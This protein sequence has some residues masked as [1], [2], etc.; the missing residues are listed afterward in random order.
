[1]RGDS[2]KSR[3][4]VKVK[5]GNPNPNAVTGGDDSDDGLDIEIGNDEFVIGSNC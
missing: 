3:F 4:I 2:K 1:M 5:L